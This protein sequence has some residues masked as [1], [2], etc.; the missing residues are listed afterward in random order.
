M[1]EQTGREVQEK[2]K[3]N[4]RALFIFSDE[5]E[6]NYDEIR[7]K[8]AQKQGKQASKHQDKGTKEGNLIKDNSC[9]WCNFKPKSKN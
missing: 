5:E 7:D 9:P 2:V 8:R 6:H 1:L 3:T 4:R